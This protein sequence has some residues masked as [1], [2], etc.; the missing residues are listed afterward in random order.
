MAQV[1]IVATGVV[2]IAVGF[3]IRA[4]GGRRAI[5]K[6][7]P[8]VVTGSVAAVIGIALAFAAL[9]MASAHWTVAMI[10]LLVTIV[11]SVY[12]Q[13]RGFLGLI[14]ILIGAVI[15]Y[16]VGA[17]FGLVDLVLCRAYI[18]KVYRYEI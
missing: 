9:D 5:D 16:I 17:L 15:G 12:L 3:I 4:A 14:P 8:P 13:G 1:G 18:D 10:T 2:N 7:L 11:L 6:I